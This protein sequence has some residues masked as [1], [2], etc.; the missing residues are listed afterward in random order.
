MRKVKFCPCHS[1]LPYDCC[2]KKFHKGQ[3]PTTPLELMRSRYSA[4]ALNLSDYIIQ[5]T[6]PS[7]REP[8]PYWKESILEF[9]KNTSFEGLEILEHTPTTV[10]FKAKLS[11]QGHDISFTEKSTFT[12]EGNNILYYKSEIIN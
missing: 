1:G 2:C 5:T 8:L 3:K 4:Y 10:T 11:Q 6:H 9:S 12:I 7:L